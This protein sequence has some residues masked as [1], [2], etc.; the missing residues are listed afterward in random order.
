MLHVKNRWK[1]AFFILLLIILI[2]VAVIG[3]LVAAPGEKEN[4]PKTALNKDKYVQFHIRTNKDDLNKLINHY[5]EKEG[6][7]GPIKYNVYLYDDVELDGTIPVFSENVRLR[8]TFEPESLKNGDLILKQK[9][10]SIGNL[11]LPVSFVL[12]FIKKSY[13]FPEWVTIYPDKREVYVGLQK[14]K[15]GR[16]D[17]KARIDTFNLPENDISFSLLFPTDK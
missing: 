2:F 8:M 14:M 1:A 4:I 16:G 15:I 13:K 12:N 9:S 6:L 11:N 5:I 10:I 17:M 3:Y 7:N